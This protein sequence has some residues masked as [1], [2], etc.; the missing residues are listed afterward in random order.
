MEIED[1]QLRM[2]VE[3]FTLEMFERGCDRT[4]Y[5]ILRSLPSDVK[6][7]AK[8]LG[9]TKVPLTRRLNQLLAVGLVDWRK[10][11]GVINKTRLTDIF[12]GLIETIRQ[13]VEDEAIVQARLVVPL[14]G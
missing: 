13:T 4:N 7:L 3:T 9:I 14:Q 8:Q 2:A 5:E 1:S 10:G 6:S 12:L 11:T